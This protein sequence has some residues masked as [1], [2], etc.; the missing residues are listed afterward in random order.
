MGQHEHDT[1]LI[2]LLTDL[3]TI[4]HK[5]LKKIMVFVGDKKK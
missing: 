2:L 3:I 1:I 4:S 5:H